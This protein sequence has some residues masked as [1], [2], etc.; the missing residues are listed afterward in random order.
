[1]KVYVAN[2]GEQNYEWETCLAQGTIATMN[3]VEVQPLWEAGDREGYIINRMREVSRAGKPVIRPVASRWYDL[4][5]IITESE[6]DIWFH[7]DQS[8]LWWTTSRPGPIEFYG[9]LEPV[10]RKRD[11]I[12]G[13]KPCDPWSNRTRAGNPLYWDALHPKA[14]NIFTV[15]STL[16]QMS[17]ENT[18]FALALIGDKDVSAWHNLK[19]WKQKAAEAKTKMG[20]VRSL[21]DREIAAMN[22]ANQAVATVGQSNGQET[23][24]VVKNKN[25]G[26]P[27]KYELEQFILELLDQQEELC[28]LSGLKMEL[29]EPCEDPQLL[30]SLD[31]IDSSGHYAPDNLQI[32]C[33]FL[34]RWKR[35]SENKEFIR[36]LDIL[37]SR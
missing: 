6:G 2:F 26:F 30:C 37:R 8:R 15:Q 18:A 9:K 22:M 21:G 19:D 29:R 23:I 12:V 34:N 17:P 3:D 16:R 13:H 31:R 25:L 28:A 11:V 4:M 35:D 20:A 14:K 5:T 36:L 7:S 1:M 27:S 24:R 33:R 32:V 10:G